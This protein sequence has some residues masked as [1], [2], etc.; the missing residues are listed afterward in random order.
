MRD[1][2]L[3]YELVDFGRSRKLE[4]FGKIVIDRPS[5]AAQGPTQADPQTW[6]EAV[7]RYDRTGGESGKWSPA[8]AIPKKWKIKFQLPNLNIQQPCREICFELHPSP[9]GHIG[10]FA[11]QATHWQWLAKQVAAARRPLKILNLFAY[12][13][14]STLAAALA[15]AKVTHVDAAA[16]IVRRARRNAVVSD[17]ADCSIRWVV[18]D[19]VK[20]CRRELKRGEQYDGVILDPP[21]YGHGP[22]GEIWKITKHLPTLLDLCGKLTSRQPTLVLT[23]CHSPGIGPAELA[24]YTAEGIFGHCG[25]PPM[26]GMLSLTSRDGRKL[27]SGV[28]ARWPG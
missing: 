28:Y 13:G 2:P 3:T 11:E 25:Q 12:T 9:F 27:P 6:R 4:R 1:T 20:Y 21:T 26:A 19:A 14:G 5:A 18:E 7:A 8:D 10:V 24:A 17:L 22:K 16:N 23:T 15:G